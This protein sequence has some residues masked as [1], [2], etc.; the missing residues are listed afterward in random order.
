MLFSSSG[1]PTLRSLL[2]LVLLLLARVATAENL[3]EILGVAPD[4][5]DKAIKK[6]Y[7]N[8]SLKYHPGEFCVL[9]ILPKMINSLTHTYLTHHI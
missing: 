3:Y 7:R 4:A 1:S 6:A 9:S 5:D 2:L 8:L